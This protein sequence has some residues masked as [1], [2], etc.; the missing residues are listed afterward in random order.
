MRCGNWRFHRHAEDPMSS[1]LVELLAAEDDD[2]ET[3][4]AAAVAVGTIGSSIVKM[5]PFAR[6]AARMNVAAV[7]Q[8][9]AAPKGMPRAVAA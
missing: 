3:A 1:E 7:A 6:Q 9:F 8:F 5:H 2:A 4:Y